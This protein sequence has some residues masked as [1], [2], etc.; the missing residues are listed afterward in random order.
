MITKVTIE[1]IA[2]IETMRRDLVRV[3]RATVV[4]VSSRIRRIPK[5]ATTKTA[6]MAVRTSI[7]TK[8]LVTL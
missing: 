7:L 5:S 4:E 8:F 3:S 6:D 1:E 2:I